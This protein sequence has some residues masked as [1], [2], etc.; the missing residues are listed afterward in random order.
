M[1]RYKITLAI[2]FACLLAVSAQ[3]ASDYLYPI[4]MVR[5]EGPKSAPGMTASRA[6]SEFTFLLYKGDGQPTQRTLVS[7]SYDDTNL[8]VFFRCFEDQMDKLKSE[9]NGRD[10]KVW[11]DDSISVLIGPESRPDQYYYLAANISGARYDDKRS[12]GELIAWDGDWSVKVTRGADHWTAVVTIPFASLGTKVPAP[13][14]SWYANFG[15]REVPHGELTA[16]SPVI[17]DFHEP[18]RFGRIIFGGSQSVTASTLLPDIG[19]P[20]KYI[21]QLRSHN[22]GKATVPFVTQILV[23][24]KAVSSWTRNAVPGERNQ[25]VAFEYLPEGKHVLQAV[26][27]RSGKV[28]MRT[29]PTP[30]DIGNHGER[31]KLY[32]SVISSFT[33]PTPEL[34]QS[35]SRLSKTL[36]EIEKFAVTARANREKWAELGQKLDAVELDI[37]R[38]RYALADYKDDKQTAGYVVGTQTALCK[39]FRDKMF[40]G[41]IGKAALVSL[42]RNEYESTQAVILAHGKQLEDVTV[43]VTDLTGSSG[44]IDASNIK[45]NL[46]DY[47]RTRKP[48]YHVEYVGW[49]PDPLM[50]MRPFDV[51]KDGVQPIWITIYAPKNTPAGTYSGRIIIK[52]TNAPET[53]VALEVRVRDFELPTRP[54]MKTAFALFPHEINAWYGRYTDEMRLDWYAFML[55]YRLNPTNIYSSRPAPEMPDIAYCVERGMNAMCLAYTHNKDAKDRAEL[56]GLLR[57][58]EEYLKKHGWWDMAYLYGFDEI[59]PDKYHELR[60]MYGWVK[61][62][63][64]DLPRM[65]TVIPNKELKGYVDIWVPVTSNYV[66]ETAEQYRKDGDEV[67]WYVCC[68]PHHPYANFFIDYPAID[69]RIIFWQCWK[70]NVPGFLYYAVNLWTTNR[71]VDGLPPEHLPH[72]DPAAQ[73]AIRAGKRWP[74]VSWNTFSFDRFNGDGH[75]IYPGPGGKPLSCIRLEC[76]RDGIED[77][78]YFYMLN[79]R[80]KDAEKNGKADSKDVVAAKKLLK[81]RESVV[82]SVTEYTLDPKALLQARDEIADM[83]ERLA[84]AD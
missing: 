25:A 23:D 64:P 11:R 81:V 35:A 62:A 27:S 14:A 72:D 67:W 84:G 61:T 54:H 3:A 10:D 51:P 80:V 74:E 38:L 44:K 63:F 47:V 31:L 69:P 55:E 6:S 19:A 83:I 45:L 68:N 60:D 20:G 78:E 71:T 42:A 75:L 49:W 48:K 21:L 52:P 13:G 58:Y 24:G 56:E 34:K 53:S 39:V 46:V 8:Y 26:I 29:A 59:T 12:A 66:H 7:L 30:V 41:E 43:S 28:I 18:Q 76:I 2:V 82:K 9:Y 33:A 70:Y 40:D 50:E 73:E 32:R 5:R 37:A 4:A 16:W 17:N 15:R 79:E 1:V 57:P 22:P 36:S 77:Y 65:C